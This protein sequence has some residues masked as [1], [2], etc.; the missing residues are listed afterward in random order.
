MTLAVYPLLERIQVLRRSVFLEMFG[1]LSLL[2][3]ENGKRELSCSARRPRR[4]RSGARRRLSVG[5]AR[6]GALRGDGQVL[7]EAKSEN[8]L[9]QEM[10]LNQ[11][12]S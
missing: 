8:P 12:L 6:C 4:R 11:Q 5:N 7:G 1:F 9:V 3:G 2:Y 10:P